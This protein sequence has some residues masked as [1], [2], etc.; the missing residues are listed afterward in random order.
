MADASARANILRLTVAETAVKMRDR[1]DIASRP[2]FR[3]RVSEQ[4]SVVGREGLEP[5]TR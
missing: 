1:P 4:F 5:P 3:V 2:V